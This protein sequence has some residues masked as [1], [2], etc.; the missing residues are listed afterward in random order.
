M[1][2]AAAT[3]TTLAARPRASRLGAHA[4]L[5][6]AGATAVAGAVVQFAVQPNTDVSDD[7]WSYPLSADARVPASAGY[8][9]LH[10]LVAVGLLAFGRS[11]A[12]GPSR[13]ARRGVAVAVFGTLMLLAAEIASIP[14]NDASVH[15]TS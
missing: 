7:M 11:G 10:A 4:L 2:T 1:S 9:V 6:G 3:P 14:I 8:A 5:A 13:R 15:D 12:A